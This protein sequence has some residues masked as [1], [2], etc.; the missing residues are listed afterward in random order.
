MSSITIIGESIT[1][2]LVNL[3]SKKGLQ[4]GSGSNQR[5]VT[6]IE[7]FIR[8]KNVLQLTTPVIVTDNYFYFSVINIHSKERFDI[9]H[10]F[11]YVEPII[12]LIKQ[13]LKNLKPDP[14]FDEER[15]TTDDIRQLIESEL[16]EHNL[17]PMKNCISMQSG[18]TWT[19]QDTNSNYFYLN[20]KKE[21]DQN[22]YLIPFENLNFDIEHGD[23]YNVCIVFGTTE[24]C[25]FNPQFGSGIY[26]INR[27]Q[28][29]R[30]LKTKAAKQLANFVL[31]NY[32]LE[33]F[34]F[35]KLN[36][37]TEGDGNRPC[38]GDLRSTGTE[39]SNKLGLKE[40]LSAGIFE[41]VPFY[42][43]H[44]YCAKFTVTFF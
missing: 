14:D 33:A 15:F 36:T 17:F 35:K 32:F 41:E 24:N 43:D 16:A 12:D 42:D 29:T 31:K 39:L 1:Q 21:Y 23:T 2:E 20:Y 5:L 22:D 37:S 8:R 4:T 34:D 19:S 10:C 30:N 25:K 38:S 18:P 44:V 11:S 6:Y 3:L 7:D 27:W 40:C 26:K 9:S 13:K 28:T